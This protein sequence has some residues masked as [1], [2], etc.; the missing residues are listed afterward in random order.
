MTHTGKTVFFVY[1][2]YFINKFGFRH[3]NA[4]PMSLANAAHMSGAGATSPGPRS[5]SALRFAPTRLSGVA[6]ELSTRPRR[7]VPLTA[8]VAP[9]SL[10]TQWAAYVAAFCALRCLRAQ[11]EFARR[12]GGAVGGAR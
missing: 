11:A 12:V 1:T 4:V 7:S 3:Q 9:H 5:A 6:N 10:V 2:L 8:I